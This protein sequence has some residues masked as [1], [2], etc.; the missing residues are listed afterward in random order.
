MTEKFNQDNSNKVKSGRNTKAELI[1]LLEDF[2]KRFDTVNLQ[3]NVKFGAKDKDQD[4]FSID[5]I[6]EFTDQSKEKWLIKTS[7]SY[8][9]DRIKGN[10]FDIEHIKLIVKSPNIELKSFFVVPD[11]ENNSSFEKYKKNVENH[12][13]VTYFDKVLKF[14]EFRH[15]ILDRCSK[16]LSQ[17]TRSNVLGNDAEKEI[18]DAFNNLN[19][20]NIWNQTG[21]NQVIKSKDFSIVQALMNKYYPDKKLKSMV[22]YDN[23]SDG[24]YYLDDLK[25][26]KGPNNENLGKPKTDVL[27]KLTFTDDTTAQINLSVKHPKLKSKKVTAHEGSIEVLMDDLAASLPSY[28]IFNDSKKFDQLYKALKNFQDAGSAKNMNPE[29]KLFLADNLSDINSWLIDYFLFGT[30]NRRFNN[31]QVANTMAIINPQ[32]GDLLYLTQEEE[33]QLLLDYCQLQKS[34]SSSFGTPFSWTYPSKK[35]GKKIQ[36]KSPLPTFDSLK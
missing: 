2:D 33:R 18:S 35:R 12:R 26:V 4:Q 20:I 23:D 8:R 5:A 31:N 14:R 36:I 28:S 3:K 13:I 6:L 22:A 34:T 17:G 16:Y 30:N 29:D 27:I 9:S 10:E 25:T 32:N 7:S 24:N 19:N 21:N 1:S 15:L 11:T